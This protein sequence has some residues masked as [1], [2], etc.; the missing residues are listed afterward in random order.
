L[1]VELGRGACLVLLDGLDEVGEDRRISTVLREFVHEFGRN[2][3]VLTSRIV[4]LDSGP[5]RKLDFSTFQVARWREEDI[6]EFAQRW[7]S[8]RPV[9]GKRQ[10]RQLDQRAEELTK[11][12]LTN[13]PLR[14]IA[15]NPLMLTILA[16]LHYANAT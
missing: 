12:I 10:K 2:Q 15:S 9:L 8:A 4:G 14:A 13:R 1:E 5:W 7:Y 16:A 3:F 6:R 11:T